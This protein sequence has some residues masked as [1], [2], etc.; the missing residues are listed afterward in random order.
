MVAFVTEINSN[1]YAIQ[2]IKENGSEEYYRH[3][4]G[5]LFEERHNDI[6]GSM[7]IFQEMLRTR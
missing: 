3:N 1:Y 6:V 7:E 4:K 5:L 2:F